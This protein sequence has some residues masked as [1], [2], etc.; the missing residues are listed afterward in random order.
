MCFG[1]DPLAVWFCGGP[2]MSA[3]RGVFTVTFLMCVLGTGGL[4]LLRAT[5]TS[6][7]PPSPPR[8]HCW[9]PRYPNLTVCSWPD[10]PHDPPT[11]YVA[12][13]SERL[14]QNH[15]RLCPLVRPTDTSSGPALSPSSDQLWHCH[16]PDLKLLTDYIINVTAVRPG[17]SSSHLSSF[18][19]EDIVKPD[20]P[21]DVWVSAHSPKAAVVGWAPPPTWANL[22]IFPLKYQILYGWENRGTPKSVRLG[23]FEGTKVDLK[24]LTG[25]RSYRFQ[26][27]AQDLLGLG[28]C[29]DWSSPVNVTVP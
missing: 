8:V 5:A 13:Y 14:R 10:S 1:L 7:N 3:A 28:Q 2:D 25:G 27:C 18:M 9:C 21:A 26:V 11:H 23:P 12:S 24:G 20:P 17:G 15:V 29:S 4:D 16:L 22:D 6:G 19:L